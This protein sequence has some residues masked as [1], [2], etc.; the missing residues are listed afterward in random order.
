MRSSLNDLCLKFDTKVLPNAVK[1]K[2]QSYYEHCRT[3]SIRI[4]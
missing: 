2:R 3:G 4:Y 1:V